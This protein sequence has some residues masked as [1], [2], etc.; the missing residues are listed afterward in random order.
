[1]VLSDLAGTVI[2]VEQYEAGDRNRIDHV[3]AALRSA[4]ITA[5]HLRFGQLVNEAAASGELHLLGSEDDAWKR[6]FDTQARK[7]RD[8]LEQQAREATGLS[9]ED[10]DM[11]ASLLFGVHSTLPPSLQP[12]VKLIRW[13]V[14]ETITGARHILGRSV[15]DRAARVSTRIADWDPV[16]RTAV[17]QSGRVYLLEGMPGRDDDASHVFD[18]WAPGNGIDVDACVNVT[19]EYAPAAI[20][21]QAVAHV[22]CETFYQSPV[23]VALSPDDD[24]RVGDWLLLYCDEQ[25][26]PAGAVISAA[27]D[28]DDV[29]VVN[30]RPWHRVGF[31]GDIFWAWWNQRVTDTGILDRLQQGDPGALE[32]MFLISGIV[33]TVTSTVTR[34]P[35]DT[36][37][38][39]DTGIGR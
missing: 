16:T 13:Q 29:W 12:L 24:V 26:E 15:S 21:P 25:L 17:T 35:P 31:T 10:R 27:T 36:G 14:R 18:M 33:A 7:H 20:N 8:L 6:A 3:I 38:T 37:S 28:N 32:D 39:G 2:F 9:S 5:P 23:H 30:P 11:A 1:M 4:W 34:R 22:P 19:A